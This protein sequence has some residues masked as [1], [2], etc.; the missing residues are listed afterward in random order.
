MSTASGI[1][2]KVNLIVNQS[3]VQHTLADDVLI[4]G[5]GV[6]SGESAALTIM[7]AEPNTGIRFLRQDTNESVKA[8]THN[9]F[10][11]QL[12]TSLS[13]NHKTNQVSTIEHLMFA[14]WA[15]NIDNALVLLSGSEVPVMD[16]S[17]RGFIDAILQ[18]GIQESRV[19]RKYLKILRTTK[20][21]SEDSFALL[22]PYDGFKVSYTFDHDSPAYDGYPTYL[23]LDANAGDDIAHELAY[24]RTFGET[25]DL[26]LA[27]RIGKCLGSDLS[28]S[29]GLDKNGVMNPE[30]LRT[31][32]EF[33]RHKLLDAIGDLY[34]FG[35]P[36]IGEFEGFKSGHYLN[37]LLTRTVLDHP[38]HFEIV[39]TEQTISTVAS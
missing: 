18:T 21:T 36:V 6:H 28:N 16:G 4:I 19:P 37:S 12:S 1:T 23:A 22:R 34:L 24:A 27:N 25:K 5:R 7:P 35:M 33:V 14:F 30:G 15:S 9:V 13:A 17:A 8:H 20:V 32:D 38:E 3:E 11:T 26:E 29:I 31:Q 2:G 10:D 39:N